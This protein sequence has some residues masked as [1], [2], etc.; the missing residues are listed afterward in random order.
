MAIQGFLLTTA[1]TGVV[2]GTPP[3]GTGNLV[4]GPGNLASYAFDNGSGAGQANKYGA[5]SA[6][7]TDGSSATLDLNT[8]LTDG[9]GNTVALAAIKVLRIRNTST[10]VSLT[11]GA[12][13]STPFLG[14]M[15]GTA[16]T[17]TIPPGGELLW[18]NSTAGGWDCSSGVADN[19][20]LLNGGGAAL[21]Y[22]LEALGI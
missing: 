16:P 22:I 18:V 3:T 13:A 19:L 6:A 1:L 10:T 14:P 4:L 11:V 2:L 7:I 21:T 12:A 5:K 17:Q 8:A 15:G 20:K 9:L